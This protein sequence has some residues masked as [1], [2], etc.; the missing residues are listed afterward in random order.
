M[1]SI[2]NQAGRIGYLV[3]YLLGAPAGILLLMWAILGDN[4]FTAG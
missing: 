3:L 2:N 1:N 4:I